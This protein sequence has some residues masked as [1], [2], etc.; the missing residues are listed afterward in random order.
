MARPGRRSN[1][2]PLP[3]WILAALVVVVVALAIVLIF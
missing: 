2:A 1:H 3:W